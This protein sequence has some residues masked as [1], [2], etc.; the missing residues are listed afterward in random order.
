MK[1]IC[2]ILIFLFLLVPQKA[3]AVTEDQYVTIV[4]PVRVSVYT[5]D[6]NK[7]IN[8]QYDVLNKLD[9]PSTW[10]LTYA[11]LQKTDVIKT[12][13]EFNKNH[14]I[15]LFFEVTP[16]YAKNA[17]VIYNETG[18]WHFAPSIFLSG[19]RQEDR[20]KL[21]DTLFAKF[22]QT[23]GYYPT[24]IGGWWI[25]SFSL[26]YMQG[27]YGVNA[28]LGL[29][30]QFATDNY[31]VWGTYW[32]TPY[33][34]SKYH[35]GIPANDLSVKSDVVTLQWAPRDPLNGYFDSYYSTQDYLQK[36]VD[37]DIGYFEKL[38][39]L[40][41]SK[42][43]NQFGQVVVGLES[44]LSPEVYSGEFAR[45]MGVV[46]KL[47]DS[48]SVKVLTM[49]DFSGWYRNRFPE[50]SPVQLIEADDLLGKPVRIIWYQSPQYRL[51]LTYD[52]RTK[53]VKIFD[54]RMYYPDFQEPYFD[55]PNAE[56]NLSIYIP[57]NFDEINNK[58]DVWILN[59]GGLNKTYKVADSL[60]VEFEK[61]KIE[62]NKDHFTVNGISDVP[63]SLKKDNN[64][65]VTS[66]GS[67]WSI[68]HKNNWIT[69]RNGFI[70][71][72]LTD[73]S[74]H[75]LARK[76]VIA[77][78]IILF[79]A[80]ISVGLGT[81]YSGISEQKKLITLTL[82]I[83]PVS[84]FLIIWY[85]ANSMDYYVSQAEV[86]ALNRLSDLPA[87]IVMVYDKECLGCE[88]Y[89]PVKPAFF[90]NKR[91]YVKY[92]GKHQI[93]YNSAVYEA[94]D[95]QEAKREFDKLNAKYI[96]LTKYAKYIEKIPFSPGD[97]NIEKIY[98]NANA[99]IWRVKG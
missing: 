70:F 44:D 84:I 9:L 42:D 53:A 54:L 99:E 49:K 33:Y 19:Y 90:S 60:V 35:A 52:Y 21:I 51:G 71:R 14:E 24:S 78:V 67:F 5:S 30:D 92:L 94:K 25:D 39:R 83:V 66:R 57:S 27:K 1:R 82:A 2:P 15:G 43:Q 62:L 97:L 46:K 74:T 28:N 11:A 40:Y 23:F 34:S 26:N 91:S 98:D 96:Y 58:D 47:K 12:I 29:A 31:R 85:R 16:E 95:Q 73:V 76:K 64:L 6:L 80:L 89:G 22:K 13:K 4:N 81:I 87:G 38:V 61:G 8:V 75:F 41:S 32:S 7:N 37:Q 65:Q 50:L 69:G 18:N 56:L 68:K 20:L 93:I 72:D 10:L 45:Q 17:D 79:I 3:F 63:S 88:W 59:L 55:V 48:Q 36:P 86:D 77:S